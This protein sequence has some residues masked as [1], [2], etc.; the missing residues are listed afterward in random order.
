MS[1]IGI[2]VITVGK[3]PIP[4]YLLREGDVFEVFEDTER[5]GASF[6]RNYLM[7]SFYDQGCDYWFIFDDDVRP[8]M[9][10]W[11][12]YFVN[13]AKE[14]WDFFGMPEYF[15]DPIVCGNGGEILAFGQCLVQFALYSRKLIETAGYYRRFTNAYGFED[16]EYAFR[17]QELQRSNKLNQGIFGFPC[18]VRVMA[19]I[20]PDDVFGNNPSPFVNM[21][22]EAKE[23]G[24]SQNIQEYNQS[25]E[26]VRNG[27]TYWSYE[28]AQG[29]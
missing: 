22:K 28:E 1:K 8:V 29:I 16:T 13:Q 2:G 17:I 12:D 27:K 21:T 15:K 4:D 5:K 24:V 19:Y 26:D 20:H 18:P 9:Q 11:Q 14:G 25:L 7:K 6:G 23:E 10:G 3:R